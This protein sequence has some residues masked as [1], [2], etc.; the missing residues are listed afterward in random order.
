MKA[1]EEREQSLHLYIVA[2]T[3]YFRV[4]L[5]L[6]DGSAAYVFHIDVCLC[7]GL[8]EFDAVLQRQ[9]RGKQESS[10]SEFVRQIEIFQ[11][12]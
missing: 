7:A 5:L 12:H 11:K 8:H 9:L 2:F 6:T 3:D 1:C 10:Q 4:Q